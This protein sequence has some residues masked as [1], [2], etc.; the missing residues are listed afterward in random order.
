ALGRNNVESA[1]DHAQTAL[2]RGLPFARLAAG[3]RKALAPLRATNT[4]KRWAEQH[5]SLKLLHGPMLGDVTGDGVSIWLR[6]RGAARAEVIVSDAATGKEAARSEIRSTVEATDFTTV[7]RVTGLTPQ[8]QYRYSVLLDGQPA[9]AENTMFRTVAAAG[10]GSKFRV[11]FGGGAGHVPKW[12]YMWD[13]IL[14]SRPQ[15][16]L[17]LGDNVYIDDPTQ[18]LTQD[19]CYYRRQARPEWRRLIAATPTY[20]IYDDHDFGTNDC[21]PGPEINQPAW[22]KDVF[23][24]FD[25]NWVNPAY[26]TPEQPGCWFDFYIGDVHFI[27]LDGRYYRSR[28]GTPTMLGPVQRAWLFHTL[29]HSTGRF[30]V[31]ASPVP[32]TIGIKPGSRD[33]WDGFAEEREQ[34]FSFIEDNGINGLFLIAADRHRTDLRITEREA[35]YDLVEFE[36]SKLTN[37]HTHGVVK[38]DGLV[39]GY[40]RTCSFALMNF[41]TTLDDPI[42][43]FDAVTIDGE[44]VHS[45]T[46]KLSQITRRQGD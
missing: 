25:R 21:V 46:L 43:R 42:V 13:T 28:E 3:P 34:I 41:D 19:Y 33:P 20:A 8:T 11:A 2:E 39:W 44:A 10:Q 18:A 1:V 40:N 22:K 24:R 27:M 17:M 23:R 4:W 45:H 9:A 14:T 38:T 26:G 7:L 35:G 29:K 31:L 37:R 36:S 5:A 32:W 16:L 30:K 12:E 6:T 15:A